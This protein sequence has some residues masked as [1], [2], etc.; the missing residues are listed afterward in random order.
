MNDT[1][2][3]VE[4]AE[5]REKDSYLVQ[6]ADQQDMRIASNLRWRIDP[7]KV[8]AYHKNIRIHPEEK[9]IRPDML[10]I[11]KNNATTQTAMVAYSGTGLV[12]LQDVILKDLK[13]DL[14]A[15]LVIDNYAIEHIGLDPKYI[16]PIVIRQVAMQEK[17]AADEKT[18]AATAKA[19]QAQAEAQ[20]DL[21]KRVVEAER[22]KKVAILMAEQ[23]AQ[24]VIL[25]AEADNKQVVLQAEA[26]K[27]QVVLSAEGEKQAGENRGAAILAIGKAEAEAQKLK[28]SAYAVQG[29][30]AFVQIEVAKH[31]SEA[32]KNI[33]GYL[34]G[35]MKINM[36]STSF[37]DSVKQVM[38]LKA[39]APLEKVAPK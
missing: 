3:S 6:S 19:L 28:L 11:I 20:A 22:D 7:T 26:A 1:P 2:S 15:Y 5:G 38:G 16:E 9:I 4:K 18:K 33:Q 31:M 14:E 35:D 24:K 25:K 27:Q 13:K 36:L 32:F 23:E 39:T 34:P 30:E 29:S 10:R 12:A 21:N 17:L 37:I 8:V